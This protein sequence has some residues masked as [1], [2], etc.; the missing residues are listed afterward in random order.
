MKNKISYG[1]FTQARIGIVENRNYRALSK[2][3]LDNKPMFSRKWLK[4]AKKQLN[5]EL[6]I[7]YCKWYYEFESIMY[8]ETRYYA[9]WLIGK[10]KIEMKEMDRF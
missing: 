5:R 10:Y 3:I 2:F 1:E 9:L 6:A 7:I 4:V 8:A